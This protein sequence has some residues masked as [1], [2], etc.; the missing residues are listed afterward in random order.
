MQNEEMHSS[1]WQSHFI[2]LLLPFRWTST[3][4]SLSKCAKQRTN[5]LI[6]SWYSKKHVS[7]ELFL[8]SAMFHECYANA[9]YE[10]E[11]VDVA[12][13]PRYYITNKPWTPIS[14][15]INRPGFRRD[16][17]LQTRAHR[18]NDRC[19]CRES[20]L[21]DTRIGATRRGTEGG[22]EGIGHFFDFWPR[23]QQLRMWRGGEW[24]W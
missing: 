11:I 6:C 13:V 4:R 21:V 20:H 19:V 10:M 14:E 3:S 12:V 22:W 23:Q 16:E 9:H 18:G 7:T 2:N 8:N 17:E 5:R 24:E 1:S 15:A